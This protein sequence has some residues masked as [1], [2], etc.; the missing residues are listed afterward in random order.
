MGYGVVVVKIPD[1][2][3]LLAIVSSAMAIAGIFTAYMMYYRRQWSAE[4]MGQRF[5]AIYALLSG[6]YF[7]RRT[8]R[9]PDSQARVLRRRRPDTGLGRQ[10][11]SGQDSGQDRLDRRERRNPAAPVPDRPD[12]AVRR[13]DFGR[14][15]RHAGAV[16]V[17]SL[18][19]KLHDDIAREGRTCSRVG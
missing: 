12:P 10:K 7:L 14:R 2:D 8:L 4:K 15:P 5:R 19:F 13:G 16:P 1:F 18:I 9:R 6:K 3:V 17:V 11:H